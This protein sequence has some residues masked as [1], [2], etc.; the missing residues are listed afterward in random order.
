MGKN[1]LWT[2]GVKNLGRW[3]WVGDVDLGVIYIEMIG[4]I[5]EHW[6]G[7][8]VERREAEKFIVYQSQKELN[9]KKAM[10]R[11]LMDEE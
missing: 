5:N 9:K 6:R 2:L 3:T 8:K 11:T 7:G 4:K 10:S 1:T